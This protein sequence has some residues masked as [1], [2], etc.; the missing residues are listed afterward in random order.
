MVRMVRTNDFYEISLQV[1]DP[2]IEFLTNTVF[3]KKDHVQNLQNL[4]VANPKPPDGCPTA[5]HRFQTHPDIL[6]N[7]I[8]PMKDSREARHII[9][10]Y[11]RKHKNIKIIPLQNQ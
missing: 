7:N 1:S 6:K 2:N 8:Y 10:S 3:L 11:L 9:K 4:F 5:K